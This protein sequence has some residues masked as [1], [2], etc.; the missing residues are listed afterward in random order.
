M[1]LAAEVRAVALICR[2]RRVTR[3]GG[4]RKSWHNAPCFKSTN[5]GIEISPVRANGL[6]GARSCTPV[7]VAQQNDG[8]VRLGDSVGRSS[9]SAVGPRHA[10]DRDGLLVVSPSEMMYLGPRPTRLHDFEFSER[11]NGVDQ[12]TRVVT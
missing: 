10:H 9:R 4:F 7:V 1:N 6:D 12:V 8:D 2:Q 3:P 5:S 11:G